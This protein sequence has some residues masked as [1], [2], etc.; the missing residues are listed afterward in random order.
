MEKRNRAKGRRPRTTLDLESIFH[1]QLIRAKLT[2]G[3]EREHRF[4]HSVGRNW[5][6]DFA[7]PRLLIAV[8]VEGGTM[9]GGRH[10]KPLGYR[11]DCHKYNCAA[12]LGWTLIRGDSEMVRRG[13]LAHYVM[14]LQSGSLPTC[15]KSALDQKYHIPRDSLW[16]Y[17][18]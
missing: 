3:L 12:L 14:D 9:Q 2:D 15:R 7:W 6:F 1:G 18:T 10:N 16:A 8:E 4:A 11:E 17:L 5:A 13:H